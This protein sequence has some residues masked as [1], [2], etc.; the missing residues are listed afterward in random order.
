MI[1]LR[2]CSNCNEFEDHRNC[3]NLEQCYHG[4]D[5]RL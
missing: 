1:C 5:D 2:Q 4:G 3:T